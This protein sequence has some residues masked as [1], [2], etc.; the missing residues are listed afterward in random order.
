[1]ENNTWTWI[2]AGWLIFDLLVFI[3][4][5]CDDFYYSHNLK[6]RFKRLKDTLTE[7]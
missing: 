7:E 4:V 6:G 2:I 1:M 3:W 5:W